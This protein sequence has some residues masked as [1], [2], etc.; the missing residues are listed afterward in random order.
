MPAAPRTLEVPRRVFSQHEMARYYGPIDWLF[1]EAQELLSSELPDGR[2][3]LGGWC[4]GVWDREEQQGWN[5]GREV[6]CLTTC[7]LVMREAFHPGRISRHPSVLFGSLLVASICLRPLPLINLRCCVQVKL[8]SGSSIEKPCG[9][10][11]RLSW[12]VRSVEVAMM[13]AAFVFPNCFRFRPPLSLKAAHKLPHPLTLLI[14]S[15]FALSCYPF[16]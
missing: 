6:I 12:L 16:L 8:H 9:S 10:G 15:R 11:S 14:A 5:R 4:L 7:R 1:Q 13:T 2:F 3:C